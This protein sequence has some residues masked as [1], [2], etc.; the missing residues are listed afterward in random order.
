MCKGNF[1]EWG[2]HRFS[3]SIF[4][5]FFFLKKTEG[6]KRHVWGRQES[7]FKWEGNR[8][9][10]SFVRC[11]WGSVR[12]N[13]KG[14]RQSCDYRDDP[15]EESLRYS[16]EMAFSSNELSYRCQQT[17]TWPSALAC[18]RVSWE[19]MQTTTG[20]LM[21]IKS[22]CLGPG[23]GCLWTLQVI[24]VCS[25]GWDPL[26]QSRPC[27]HLWPGERDDMYHEIMNTFMNFF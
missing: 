2:N 27:W 13:T 25:Q 1:W 23:K 10:D 17:G 3:L 18:I 21:K 24:L 20:Y 15:R 6:R 11:H 14:S 8:S 12:Y 26:R 4:F 7:N 19:L 9:V 22:E 5:F 16:V